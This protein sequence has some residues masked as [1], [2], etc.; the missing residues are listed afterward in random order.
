MP[1]PNSQRIVQARS[2]SLVVPDHGRTLTTH[3]L[4]DWTTNRAEI[5]NAIRPFGCSEQESQ[6]FVG[7]LQAGEGKES[8][9]RRLLWMK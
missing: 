9:T 4:P 5:E 6:S 2:L 1:T 7:I 3:R 8:P